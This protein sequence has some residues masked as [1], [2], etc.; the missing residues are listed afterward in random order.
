MFDAFVVRTTK[1]SPSNPMNG[2][3]PVALLHSGLDFELGIHVFGHSRRLAGWGWEPPTYARMQSSMHTFPMK[4]DDCTRIVVQGL[5]MHTVN[6]RDRIV[7][8]RL[9]LDRIIK[10]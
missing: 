7:F 2:V 5:D 10:S 1:D 9:I 4:T 8:F 6:M 3:S